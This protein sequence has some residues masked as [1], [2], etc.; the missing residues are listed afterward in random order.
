MVDGVVQIDQIDVL[1]A[2][3]SHKEQVINKVLDFFRIRVEKQLE[4]MDN[5]LTEVGKNFLADIERLYG[6]APTCPFS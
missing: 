5:E 3:Y 2:K 4:A 6:Y 1:T